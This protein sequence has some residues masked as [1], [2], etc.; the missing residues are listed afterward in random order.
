[1][2]IA[3]GNYTYYFRKTFVTDKVGTPKTVT[4]SSDDS[5]SVYLDGA[6]KVTTGPWTTVSSFTFTPSAY[7]THVIA[8][9]ATNS[10]GPGGLIV[11][12]R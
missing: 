4:V 1:M 6:L 12:V 7:G 2:P 9:S 11:D 10:G 3:D 8:V 5:A